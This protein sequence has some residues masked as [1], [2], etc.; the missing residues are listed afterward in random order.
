G[1]GTEN[2]NLPAFVVM[3]D[4][5]GG[6]IGGPPNWGNGF[7]PAAHQGTQFRVSGDPIIN[8]S[9]PAGI[10]AG[11]QRE[12]L[13]LLGRLNEMHRQATPE[14]SELAA[15]T[16]SYELAFRMQAS[17][18]EAVDLARETAETKRLY[19]LDDPRTEKFG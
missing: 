3:L 10:G 8:L 7:M 13:D 5:R 14:N 19:G 1:L 11:Q 18:P 15:R 2:E 17:A 4:H 9:P 6:P 16:A 12:S